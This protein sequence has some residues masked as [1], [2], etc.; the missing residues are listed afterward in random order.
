M[1]G[2]FDNV[3]VVDLELF[4]FPVEVDIRT[5]GDDVRSYEDDKVRFA[6]CFS[7]VPEKPSDKGEVPEERH[8]VI[9]GGFLIFDESAENQRLAVVEADRCRYRPG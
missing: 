7:A 3:H 9:E 8:F 2:F 1:N 5:A 4:E 6:A